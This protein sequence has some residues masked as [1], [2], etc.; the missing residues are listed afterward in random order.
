MAWAPVA[1]AAAA[2]SCAVDATAWASGLARCQ[3]YPQQSLPVDDVCMAQLHSRSRCELGVNR[4]C[5]PRG[6][7]AGGHWHAKPHESHLMIFTN[8]EGLSEKMWH[9]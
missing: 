8:K 6:P 9:G 7:A 1:A 4:G 5:D 3:Q 2:C